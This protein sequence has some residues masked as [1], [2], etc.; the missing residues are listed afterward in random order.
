MAYVDGF[1]MPMPK[2]NLAAYRRLARAAA[3]IWMD[4]GALAYV[5]AAGDD[6]DGDFGVPFPKLAK[7]KAGETVVFAFIRYRS[8]AHRDRVN[9]RIMKDPRMQR[10]MSRAMPFD[11]KRM[12]MG[13]F[14]VIVDR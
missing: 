3:R 1:V 10:M 4:H 7:L 2:R 13:G 9:A 5:E 8:R 11:T 12:T 14:R 6:L